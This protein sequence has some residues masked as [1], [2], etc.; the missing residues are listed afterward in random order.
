MAKP[1]DSMASLRQIIR[2]AEG[3]SQTEGKVL[4]KQ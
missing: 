4:I 3:E 2:A 1:A